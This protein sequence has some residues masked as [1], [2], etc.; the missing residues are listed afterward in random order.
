MRERMAGKTLHMVRVF[1][2][3]NYFVVVKL[4]FISQNNKN[5]I[6]SPVCRYELPTDD[7]HFEFERKKRM[8]RRKL[9]LRKD[10]ILR[11]SIAQLKEMCKSLSIDIVDCIAKEEIV[12]KI[13][14]SGH[15]ELIES[16]PVINMTH[17]EFQVNYH[18]T[19]YVID[20]YQY[21]IIYTLE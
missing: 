3:E 13:I 6:P 8:K 10:Q 19:T 14:K 1:P 15:V 21:F 7:Q 12:E 16:V 17:A 9:R 20:H 11:N 18:F 2:Y 5:S 4:N